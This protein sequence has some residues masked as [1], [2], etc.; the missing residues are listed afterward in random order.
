MGGLSK[1]FVEHVSKCSCNDLVHPHS[2]RRAM[3]QNLFH[4][5]FSNMKYYLPMALLHLVSR[6]L[7]GFHEDLL[8][9]ASW[10]FTQLVSGGVLNGY[11]IA[12]FICM[13]RN[14]LG[15]FRY[16]TLVFAPSVLGGLLTAYLPKR[17][18]NVEHTGIFQSLIESFL[19]QRGNFVTKLLAS[20]LTLQTLVFMVC[21]AVVL[22]GKERRWHNGFWFLTPE[23]VPPSDASNLGLYI[24]QGNAQVFA[25]WLCIGQF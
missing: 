12:T 15:E 2:C 23:A 11:L 17:V 7:R 22:L 8:Q 19:L 3:L 16:S 6:K 24:L 1:Y 18:K 20:S 25:H 9:D 4:F 5:V 10:Y 21:S 14:F 13:M